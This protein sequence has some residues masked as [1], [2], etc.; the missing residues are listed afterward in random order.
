[1]KKLL[2]LSLLPS[3]ASADCSTR[4]GGVVNGGKTY[5]LKNSKV[6]FN[7]AKN[8]CESGDKLAIWETQAQFD[9]VKDFASE[10]TVLH[11]FVSV[12]MV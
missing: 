7:S 8:G 2:L 5:Y 6:T 11:G 4:S 9:I 1:M 10:L 12:E 3:L